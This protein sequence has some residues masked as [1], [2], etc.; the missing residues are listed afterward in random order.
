MHHVLSAP[1]LEPN[2]TI[3]KKHP[4]PITVSLCSA[5]LDQPQRSN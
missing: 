4:F 1:Q 5:S 3:P 2:T